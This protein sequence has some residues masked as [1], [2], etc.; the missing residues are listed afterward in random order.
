M[1][2]MLERI[3][4]Q[5][6]VR[7]LLIS[8]LRTRRTTHAYLFSGPKG[9]GKLDV[10]CAFAQA[11]VC[12]EQGCGRCIDCKKALLRNHPDIQI[13]SP[14]GAQGYLI[15]QIREV[16]ISATRA[17]I[18]AQRKVFILKDVEQLGVSAANAFLKT[19]EE[20]SPRVVLI[21]LT[22]HQDRVLPTIVSRCQVV[23]FRAIPEADAL[24]EVANETGCTRELARIAVNICEGSLELARTFVIS[25]DLQQLRKKVL[26]VLPALSECDAWDAIKLSS[27]FSAGG[28]S[29]IEELQTQQEEELA[30]ADDFLAKGARKQLEE[31]HKRALTAKKRQLSHLRCNI[32][33]SW[34][35]DILL[36]FAG[37]SRLIVNTDVADQILTA[38][39]KTTEAGVLCAIES[40]ARAR[41]A[42]DYNVSLQLC[43]DT[44]LLDIRE[45][46]YGPHNT[47]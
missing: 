29:L 28:E 17:P 9:A 30:V 7:D 46:L 24:A 14:K 21:L 32:A 5:P 33:E 40:L 25:D 35:R 10:A 31:A 4:L 16:V 11:L 6:Q 18:Q 27:D 8:M 2:A 38:A 13:I 15:D 37:C 19:L 34:L 3:T 36:V 22:S 20:P 44:L 43:L 41:S 42:M 47:R 45:D 26:D 12:D 39:K 1:P 23:P